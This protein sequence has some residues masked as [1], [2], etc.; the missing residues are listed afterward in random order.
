MMRGAVTLV[1]L[2][3]LHVPAQAAEYRLQVS[4]LFDTSFAHFFDGKIGRGEGELALER[5][6]RSLDGALVPKGALLYDRTFQALP[7]GWAQGF[8]AITARR[9]GPG[10]QGHPGSRRGQARRERQA[11]GGSG[12]GGQAG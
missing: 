10:L 11:V 1:L 12:L 6:E 7:A 5:L 8:K 9:G 3:A 2:L 4:N